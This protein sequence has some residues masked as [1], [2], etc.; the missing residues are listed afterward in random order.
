MS[1]SYEIRYLST[2]EKDLAAIFEYI[3]YRFLL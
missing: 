3:R 2:A 1:A